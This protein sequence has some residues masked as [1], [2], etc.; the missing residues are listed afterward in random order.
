[1]YSSEYILNVVGGGDL[2][3]FSVEDVLNTWVENWGWVCQVFG[4]G[5]ACV[6]EPRG[7]S[8]KSTNR[9][10]QVLNLFFL[11]GST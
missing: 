7:T 6:S 3:N 4:G 10:D 11:E 2:R 9:S 5:G 1:M 8:W